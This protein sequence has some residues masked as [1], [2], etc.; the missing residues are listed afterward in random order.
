MNVYQVLGRTMLGRVRSGVVVGVARS[1]RAFSTVRVAP[2]QY[3]ARSASTASIRP[4]SQLLSSSSSAASLMNRCFSASASSEELSTILSRELSE[5][6]ENG[7]LE[8]PSELIELKEELANEWDILDDNESGTVKMFSKSGRVSIVFHC[9]DTLEVD[10]DDD[11]DGDEA[12][13]EVRFTLTVQKAGKTIVMNCVSVE[14]NAVVETVAVTMEDVET[15]H[16]SG[17][18]SDKLYQGPQFDELEEDLQE[19]FTTFVQTDCGVHTNVAA[20]ISMYADFK[21]QEEY[22]RWLKQ[23]QSIID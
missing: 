11:D 9:Q 6:E 14:A 20:F 7:A 22:I 8:M 3:Q 18:V 10:F 21:E 2:R 13:P 4:T 17:K 23:V 5:E 1:S 15:I 12:S 19:A 16:V